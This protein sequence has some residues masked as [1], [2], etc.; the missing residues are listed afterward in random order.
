M[1]HDEM[2]RF[3]ID[4]KLMD[5]EFLALGDHIAAIREAPTVFDVIGEVEVKEGETLFINREFL[6]VAMA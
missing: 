6:P 5:V 4:K 2:L 3:A 1:P